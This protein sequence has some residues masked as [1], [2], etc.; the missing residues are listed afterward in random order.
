MSCTNSSVNRNMITAENFKIHGPKH[1]C[2]FI[3]HNFVHFS[4]YVLTAGMSGRRNPTRNSNPRRSSTTEKTGKHCQCFSPLIAVKINEDCF[5]LS[6]FGSVFQ[7]PRWLFAP[8]FNKV[9]LLSFICIFFR[10]N[11]YQIDHLCLNRLF[12]PSVLWHCWLD[13]VAY[14]NH[15]RNDIMFRVGC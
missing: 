1:S 3:Q 10:A 8:V 6:Q 5:D 9:S 12:W 15:P 11:F 13:Y 14:K 2:D 4:H 7:V